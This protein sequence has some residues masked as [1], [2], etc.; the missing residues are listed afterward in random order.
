MNTPIMEAPQAN[1]EPECLSPSDGLAVVVSDFTDVFG[2]KKNWRTVAP[3]TAVGDMED[4]FNTIGPSFRELISRPQRYRSILPSDLSSE[5]GKSALHLIQTDTDLNPI[6]L[7]SCRDAEPQFARSLHTL[8]T[9]TQTRHREGA[10]KAEVIVGNDG[11]TPIAFKKH[12]GDDKRWLTLGWEGF[13]LMP[14]LIVAFDDIEYPPDTTEHEGILSIPIGEVPTPKIIR[15]SFLALKIEE[16]GLL[17]YNPAEDPN[18]RL[19]EHQH[20][21]ATMEI[22]D[23]REELSELMS[24][25]K[26]AA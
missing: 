7:S 1:Y 2:I 13:S 6:Y 11:V 14:G 10:R 17:F 8:S 18:T 21:V 9:G 15:A 20:N 23:F 26:V 22:S 12:R 19:Y 25:T 16:R 5:F 24:R 3:R 4:L